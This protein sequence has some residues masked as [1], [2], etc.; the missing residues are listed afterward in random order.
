MYCTLGECVLGSEEWARVWVCETW[1]A[2]VIAIGVH[3]SAAFA[4][5]AADSVHET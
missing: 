2:V 5:A 4:A 3:V 1:G